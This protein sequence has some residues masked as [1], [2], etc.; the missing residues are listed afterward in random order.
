MKRKEMKTV[1]T[2][3]DLPEDLWRKVKIEA[4]EERSDL[5]SIIIEAVEAHLRRR[6]PAK[7]EG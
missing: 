5:R 6:K 1:R 7:R 3:I 4:V 2:T